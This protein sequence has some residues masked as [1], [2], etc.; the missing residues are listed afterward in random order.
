MAKYRL[1]DFYEGSETLAEARVGEFDSFEE[2]MKYAKHYNDA[3][4][5]GECD[6]CFIEQ[7]VDGRFYTRAMQPC[8]LYSNEYRRW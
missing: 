7:A 5:D 1:Y 6:L 2:L 3:E 8:P 4:T